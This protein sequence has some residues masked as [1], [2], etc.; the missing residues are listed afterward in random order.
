[1]Y[2]S[3]ANAL[4]GPAVFGEY[5]FIYSIN[6]FYWAPTQFYLERNKIGEVPDLTECV[7]SMRIFY[8][9]LKSSYL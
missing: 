3:D 1:M 8:R 2:K 4:W 7:Y 6:K 5:E 9:Y